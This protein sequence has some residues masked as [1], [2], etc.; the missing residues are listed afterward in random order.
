MKS[1]RRL[2]LSQ[3]TAAE[4]RIVFAQDVPCRAFTCRRFVA[5]A[6]LSED[7]RN[8]MRNR[9]REPRKHGVSPA[10]HC[11]NQRDSCKIYVCPIRF[12]RSGSSSPMAQQCDICGK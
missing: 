12:E 1:V 8:F 7:L 10:E 4:L 2:N 11:R 9:S 5:T 6:G 3:L